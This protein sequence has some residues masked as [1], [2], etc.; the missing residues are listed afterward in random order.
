[1]KRIFMFFVLLAGFVSAQPS[2]TA[3]PAPHETEGKAWLT[4]RLNQLQEDLYSRDL[5]KVNLLFI[6]DSIT[7]NWRYAGIGIW[8]KSFAG[9][10]Y[11]ALNLGVGGD[12]TENVLYR[13][14]SKKAGGMGNLDSPDLKPKTIVLMIGTNNLFRHQPDQIIKGITAVLNR[15]RELEPQARIILCSVLPT[16]DDQRN[17]NLVIPVNDAIQ[18]LENMEWM[19]L[20]SV[21]T[22]EN[23]AQRRE[24]FQDGVHLNKNGYRVWRDR[25]LDRLA[26]SSKEL[27]GEHL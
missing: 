25:L 5:S 18:T 26:L 15:L 2:P 16:Q 13:L 14:L 3:V 6:G 21:F 27:P 10:P 22:D 23:G 20:Y 12:R 19:D 17:R 4:D 24:F 11:Y 8:N 9:E 1:M 7:Q